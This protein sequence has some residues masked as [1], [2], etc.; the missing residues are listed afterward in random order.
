MLA[1][2]CLWLKVGKPGKGG[3]GYKYLSELV[4]DITAAETDP[5]MVAAVHAPGVQ[6][7]SFIARMMG[8]PMEV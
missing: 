5:R 2:F 1:L 6:I 3:Q 8:Y 7:G 4:S